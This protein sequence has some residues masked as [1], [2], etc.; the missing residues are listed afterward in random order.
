[1]ANKYTHEYKMEDIM[2][3]KELYK[4]TA[5]ITVFENRNQMGIAA[6]KAIACKIR[7]LQKQQDEINIMF[8]AAPSQNEVLAQL[9]T[10]EGICWDKINGFHMDEYIGMGSDNPA[11]FVNYLKRVLFTQVPFMAPDPDKEAERYADLLKSHPLHICVLGIGE[12]GH[13][14]FNDPGVADFKDA[15]LVKI[16]SLD[17]RCKNQQVHDG[18]FSS[19]D[20]VP[21]RALTVTIP[22]LT[23]ARYL[24]CC[25]PASTKAEAVRRLVTE[26]ISCS[27]PATILTMTPNSEIYLDADSAADILSVT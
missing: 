14:A 23:A 7:E 12:N 21:S 16:V 27:C 5:H 1:M 13:L 25:V 11:G 4:G 10:E 8:A 6:G 9:I 19:I 24:Y 22:G 26:E 2:I 18:C 20:Q 17:E 3:I 15:Q